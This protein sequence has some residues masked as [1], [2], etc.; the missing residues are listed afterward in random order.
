MSH[1]Y[2]T[3]FRSPGPGMP[4]Y[5][6]LP[7]TQSDSRV[8]GHK[9][10]KIDGSKLGIERKKSSFQFGHKTRVYIVGLSLFCLTL[11][12]I[13]SLTFNFTVIC[14]NDIVAEH[15][16][17]NLS[18]LHWMESATEKSFLFSGAAIGAL[19]GLIP[20]VPLI[21]WL[22]IRFVLTAS[23]FVS[24]AGSFLF[25]MAVSFHYYA[26]LICRILQGLGIT[27]VLTAVGVIPGVW[28]PTNEMSTFLAL[29]S[30]AYQLSS[31]VSMPVSGLL[32]DS[33][34]GWRSIYYLFG[35]LTFLGYILFYIFYADTPEMHRNVSEKELTRIQNGKLKTVKEA[36]PYKAICM[37][38]TVL[39]AWLSILGGNFGF[40]ISVLYGPTYLRE[41]LQFDVKN[42][43][44]ASAFPFLLSALMKFVAGQ[45]SDRINFISEKTRFTIC[46]VVSQTG[47]AAGFLV[48]AMSSDRLV[49]QIAYTFA[50][51]TS[52]LNIVG[53]MKCVQLRCRQ[54]V[55]FALSVIAFCAYLIQFV[56]PI[57]VGILVA[58][59]TSEEWSRFFVIVSIIVV[60]MSLPFP[61]LA[62]AETGPYVKVMKKP[63]N[64]A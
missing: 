16:A 52:G 43:G 31:I 5:S 41:I 58:D 8:A 21:D 13:N 33:Q 60:V 56:A 48:M 28:A 19:I 32:C 18:G 45:L 46:A 26:V 38:P 49:S 27:V 54:H 42:T 15:H 59:N 55:H 9:M 11:S 51:T 7:T 53:T 39:A 23:G 37:D 29:L 1:R 62:S 50:I 34:F 3:N 2:W 17:K 4:S 30:C 64:S 14:M 63:S 57:G 61:F 40:F 12:Q 24:A 25:P 35:A 20:S 22:G 47:V 10:L 44:F 6:P 36:V